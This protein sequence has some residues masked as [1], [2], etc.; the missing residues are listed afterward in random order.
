MFRF[1]KL[2]AI[3]QIVMNLKEALKDPHVQIIDVRSFMEYQMGHVSGSVNIP[4]NEIPQHVTEF[5]SATGPLVFC[6]A[7]GNRSGQAVYYL[8]ESGVKNVINGFG[9]MNVNYEI[10]QMQTV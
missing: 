2:C 10:S 9:W 1:L 6:C 8:E 5:N 7:S 3:K 4:L